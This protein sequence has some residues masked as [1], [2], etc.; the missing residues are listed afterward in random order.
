MKGYIKNTRDVN[1]KQIIFE[2]HERVSIKVE[3]NQVVRGGILEPVMLPLCTKAENDFA[4]FTIVNNLSFED[5]YAGK[6]CAALDRQHP[7]DL[8]DIFYNG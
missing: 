1:A 5:V 7:R 3:I 6:I 2:N 8:F 4:N